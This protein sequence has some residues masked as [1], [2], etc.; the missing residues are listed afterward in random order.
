MECHRCLNRVIYPQ[1]Y[2]SVGLEESRLLCP[3]C[4]IER[5]TVVERD[6]TAGTTSS[7]NS[8]TWLIDH[9]GHLRQPFAKRSLFHVVSVWDQ[10]ISHTSTCFQH[11]LVTSSFSPSEASSCTTRSVWWSSYHP[12]SIAGEQSKALAPLVSLPIVRR[13]YYQHADAVVAV[14][15]STK[16]ASRAGMV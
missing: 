12:G 2:R 11:L 5:E 7:E 14:S 3:H 10:T 15:E 16:A 6:V 13:T 1:A 9:R 8:S 4:L